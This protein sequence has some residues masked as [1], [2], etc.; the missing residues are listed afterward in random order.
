MDATVINVLTG[1]IFSVNLYDH[2]LAT[3]PT[4]GGSAKY[5]PS[6][7]SSRY[8][9]LMSDFYRPDQTSGLEAQPLSMD[10]FEAVTS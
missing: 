7:K 1:L 6:F 5:C 2:F 9:I 10:P 3:G 8:W 4:G